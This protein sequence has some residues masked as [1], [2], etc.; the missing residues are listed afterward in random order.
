V[1]ESPDR[2]DASGGLLGRFAPRIR[3]LPARVP[4]TRH[5]L[6]VPEF[7]LHQDGA[8]AVYYAPFDHVNER[9]RVVVVGITPGWAQME[10][11]FRQARADLLA[12]RPL[13]EVAERAKYA[14]SFAGSMR[15]NLVAML[16]GIGVPVALGIGS[17]AALFGAQRSLL[18]PTSVVRYPVLVG[19]AAANYTGHA[20]R[21]LR[22]PLLCRYAFGPFA[23]ELRRTGDALVVPLGHAVSEALAALRDAGVP[24]AERCL[25]GFP[26]P[27][28]ANGH[29][30][31]EYA[32]ARE[33]LAQQVRSWGAGRRG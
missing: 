27:S 15:A 20:P 9:A 28:G 29:R 22:H 33:T 11:S 26:H 31:R 16:D 1:A 5:D 19:G 2:A 25:L 23:D 3:T 30:Q 10:V 4:L 6:L 14:A 18:H 13:P 24:P 21:L 7:L 8:L 17:A 32:A 12:G